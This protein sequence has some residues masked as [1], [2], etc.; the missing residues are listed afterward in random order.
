[1]SRGTWETESGAHTLLSTGLSPSTVRLS[2]T[3]R[4]EVWVCNSCRILYDPNICSRN[5]DYAT[6]TG[7]T[8]NRFGLFPFRSPLLRKSHLLSIPR[9]TEMFQFTPFAAHDY[10]FIVR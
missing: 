6:R 5:P 7:L 2:R 9:V 1:M 10:V 4:L 8:R 3:V